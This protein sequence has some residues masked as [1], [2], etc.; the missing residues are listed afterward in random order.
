MLKTHQKIK[1]M[2]ESNECIRQIL[3]K[4]VSKFDISYYYTSKLSNDSINYRKNSKL[5]PTTLFL[6]GLI[7]LSS[8]T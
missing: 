4:T 2:L 7:P 6:F 1:F 5:T 8:K 3:M